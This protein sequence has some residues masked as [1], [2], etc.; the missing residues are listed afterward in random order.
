M[1]ENIYESKSYRIL[2]YVKNNIGTQITINKCLEIKS[3]TLT[4]KGFTR[5]DSFYFPKLVLHK[6]NNIL[7]LL[8]I[9]R[10]S[11]NI[12]RLL[13]NIFPTCFDFKKIKKL[14]FNNLLLNNSE[15]IKRIVFKILGEQFDIYK[16]I[17]NIF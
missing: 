12:N 11:I 13:K 14:N 5:T 16:Y 4:L 1:H 7:H 10:C 17:P 6:S 15:F 3:T 9:E 8:I 2:A